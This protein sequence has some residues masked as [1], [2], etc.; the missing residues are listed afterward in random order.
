MG[1]GFM[2]AQTYA[3]TQGLH[4]SKMSCTTGARGFP[5]GVFLLLHW[6]PSKF[7]ETG[8][9]KDEVYEGCVVVQEPLLLSRAR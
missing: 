2:D 6:L 5:V 4:A 7:A 8:L 9:F 1:H 3:W